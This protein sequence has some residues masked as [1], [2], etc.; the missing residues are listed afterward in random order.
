MTDLR[1]PLSEREWEVARLVGAGQSYRLIGRELGITP[2]TARVHVNH[3]AD[4][5]PWESNPDLPPYR[6]VMLWVI[7]HPRKHVA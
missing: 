6:R 4:V 2:G 1:R 5:L 7:H 3:I